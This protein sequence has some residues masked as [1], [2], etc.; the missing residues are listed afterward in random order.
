MN[1]Y[2]NTIR[3]KHKTRGGDFVMWGDDDNHYA[4][5]ALSNIRAVVHHDFDALYLFQM[6]NDLGETIPG[7]DR[8]VEATNVDSGDH[9]LS[10]DHI[11]QR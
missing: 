3:N 1:D 5:D 9:R 8:E 2:A 4:A 11:A 10:N 6:L 7:G